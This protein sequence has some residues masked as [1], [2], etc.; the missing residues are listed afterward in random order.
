LSGDTHVVG[1]D[2]LGVRRILGRG[3]DSKAKVRIPIS[4]ALTS[5]WSNL[6][7]SMIVTAVRTPTTSKSQT[8]FIEGR[9]EQFRFG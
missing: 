9:L 1:Y 5:H 3:E 7:D 6:S 2:L 4:S 8:M